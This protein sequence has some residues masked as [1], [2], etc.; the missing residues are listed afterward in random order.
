MRS[1]TEM[2]LLIPT[3]MTPRETG[4]TAKPGTAGFAGELG[5]ALGEVEKL[6]VEADREADLVAHGAGNLHE[7]AIALEKADVSMR[8]AMK[9]RNK[10]VEAYNEIMRMGL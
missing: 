8:L 9:V 2:R 1:E 3:E 7:L 5:K 4:P 6:Q 10:M